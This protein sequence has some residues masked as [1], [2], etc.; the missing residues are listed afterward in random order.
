MRRDANAMIQFRELLEKLVGKIFPVKLPT[1]PESVEKVTGTEDEIV[2]S[3]IVAKHESRFMN[4][5][6]RVRAESIAAEVEEF[7][8]WAR[9]A[10]Q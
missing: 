2:E 8:E 1:I 7:A 9:Y 3:G 5:I 10:C 4:G 6:H